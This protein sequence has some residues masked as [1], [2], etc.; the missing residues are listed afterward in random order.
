[1]QTDSAAT[2]S[3][4]LR[5]VK[6]AFAGAALAALALGSAACGAADTSPAD[7]QAGSTWS[8]TWGD[9]DPRPTPGGGKGL[10]GPGTY[11]STWS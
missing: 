8:L 4:W 1:M 7:D 2:S 6:V 9:D 5:R 10:P 11:G 3:T